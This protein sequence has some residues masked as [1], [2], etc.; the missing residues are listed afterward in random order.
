MRNSTS[1]M[2]SKKIYLFLSVL[3]LGVFVY[4]LVTFFPK[5]KSS[6]FEVSSVSDTQVTVEGNLLK[7]TGEGEE[8]NYYLEALDGTIIYLGSSNIADLYNGKRVLVTGTLAISSNGIK[9]MLVENIK[10]Y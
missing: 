2:F 6:I 10:A 7:E 4:S 9:S 5:T 8:G 1:S 3:I